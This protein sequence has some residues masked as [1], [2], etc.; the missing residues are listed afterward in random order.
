M[1]A[2]KGMDFKMPIFALVIIWGFLGCGDSAAE[3]DG[4][5]DSGPDGAARQ[6]EGEAGPP[7]PD[8]SQFPL[9]VLADAG[10]LLVEPKADAGRPPED[11][12]PG[13]SGPDAQDAAPP[14]P[15]ACDPGTWDCNQI[16]SDGCEW[17]VCQRVAFLNSITCEICGIK[18]ICGC[19]PNIQN[20]AGRCDAD[21]PG[22]G[23][24]IDPG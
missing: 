2:P 22:D 6:S 12:G 1:V 24:D 11:G 19:G 14:G 18:E 10:A 21:C 5:T 3:D 9:L 15:L 4:S 16:R 23:T 8:G 20:R 17:S 7:G 13:D